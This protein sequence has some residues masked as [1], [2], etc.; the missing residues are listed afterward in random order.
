[1]HGG[2]A[3]DAWLL[4]DSFAVRRTVE[5]MKSLVRS[6]LATLVA[7]GV[8][9]SLGWSAS[10]DTA[11]IVTTNP[12]AD[13]TLGGSPLT[14]TVS[15]P[16]PGGSLSLW[17]R[18]GIELPPTGKGI[19]TDGNVVTFHN[20]MLDSGWYELRWTYQDSSGF[21]RF[22]VG[23]V[24]EASWTTS[25]TDEKKPRGAPIAVY[26]VG[27]VL[28]LLAVAALRKKPIVAVVV[29]AALVSASLGAGALLG[30]GTA[31]KPASLSLC[32]ALGNDGDRSSIATKYNCAANWVI[33]T[34]AG[35]AAK[36]SQLISSLKGNT[37]LGDSNSQ[38]CHNVSHSVGRL[39]V[40]RGYEISK[41]AAVD[42]NDC[43]WG[44]TH[45]A[46]E[47]SAQISTDAEWARTAVE[48][49]ADA[50]ND[51]A[52]I[53][54]THGLGHANGYRTNNDATVGLAICATLAG[55]G[56]EAISQCSSATIMSWTARMA[57]VMRYDG[58][59][60]RSQLNNPKVLFPMEIC[61]TLKGP[62]REGCW[63]GAMNFLQ[64]VLNTD[65][66]LY[67][68]P[69]IVKF[70]QEQGS[71]AST[72][73]SFMAYNSGSLPRAIPHSDVA[74]ACVSLPQDLKVSCMQGYAHGNVDRQSENTAVQ[75]AYSIEV[76]KQCAL[77]VNGY[78]AAERK[79]CLG[80]QDHYTQSTPVTPSP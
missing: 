57:L 6:L 52:L 41:L 66:P 19:E 73:I 22:K 34:A 28:V 40:E 15:F 2:G 46:L 53:Q 31:S 63:A 35:D 37:A 50:K 16:G 5:S 55:L 13:S 38:P 26:V 25:T 8:L 71:D 76:E 14:L 72:C 49:C 27:F 11:P 80:P 30:S 60:D 78:S 64:A 59:V 69:G 75:A 51:G 21:S 47:R 61:P 42:T 70:C 74:R 48:A 23:E 32:I 45:G 9:A 68:L 24:L 7:F 62:L 17:D 79:L 3:V 20:P 43:F 39:L 1:M 56:D 36:M 33:E 29:V 54:C 4:L 77:F 10:A 58:T 18:L 12:V 44:M 65:E 67:Q